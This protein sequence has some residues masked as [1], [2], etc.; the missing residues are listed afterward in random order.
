M[1]ATFPARMKNSI[2]LPTRARSQAGAIAAVAATYFFFL[3]FAEFAFLE[4]SEGHAGTAGGTRVVLAALGLSGISGAAAA[5]IGLRTWSADKWLR[6][7]FRGCAAGAIL[8]LVATN[9]PVMLASAIVSGASLGALTVTLAARLRHATGDTHLGRCIGAGTGA[10][11]G[12]CNLPWIFHASPAAQTALA[13]AAVLA[14]SFLPPGRAAGEVPAEPRPLRRTELARWIAV[15]LALVWLDSA[16]FYIVQHTDSLRATTWSESATLVGNAAVHLVAALAAGFA[17]D[18]QHRAAVLTLAWA[19]LALAAVTLNGTLR[20]AI[21]AHWLYTAGVSC[22]SVVLVEVPARS[23]A[24]RVGALVFGIAGW[25]GSALGIGMA[26]DLAS[27]PLAFI[28]VA[29]A[30]AALAL[31]WPR[32]WALAALLLLLAPRWAQADE[33]ARG[34]DVYIA[35]GCIHCHSQFIR[36][37]VATEV[38][39]WGP[40]TPLPRALRGQPPVFGTRRQGPDLSNVGN[41]RSAQWNRLHLMAPQKISPGSR[42]PS[43]AHLFDEGDDRGPALLAYLA[44]LG[45]DS[46]GWRQDQVAAWNPTTRDGIDPERAAALFSRLCAQCHGREGRG[47]GELAGRLS[48]RPPD[49]AAQPWRRLPPVDDPERILSQIIKFGLPGSPMA[50]HEYLPDKE[51]VGLARYVRSLHKESSSPR[52]LRSSHEDPDR[53]R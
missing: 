34:R 11:Y 13:A 4:L 21:P 45:E 10:A 46:I 42:M 14:A 44:S 52:P 27:I 25:A 16:S 51:I 28:A 20:E 19:S 24:P 26:Q 9:L 37:R 22:Y 36:P 38:L 3:I 18:R 12:L 41:R 50:G 31:G 49:W 30:L 2:E 33:T 5:G 23:G 39:N 35:E 40:A 17:L 6:R 1:V 47:D 48:I 43:Y 15:L 8:A 7:A 29:T 32:S 53:R